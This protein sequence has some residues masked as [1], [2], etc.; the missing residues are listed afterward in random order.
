[1]LGRLRSRPQSFWPLSVAPILVFVGQSPLCFQ[2]NKA[3]CPATHHR[4]L[5]TPTTPSLG[6]G[7]APMV[8]TLHFCIVGL[9]TRM[10]GAAWVN[11][12]P[13]VPKCSPLMP[14]GSELPQLA[15]GQIWKVDGLHP[16]V[17]VLKLLIRTGTVATDLGA[18]V[19]LGS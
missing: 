9:L 6:F 14:L 3:A 12:S 17:I 18:A 5:P 13:L 2:G 15:P 8:C 10:R 16:C 7:L 11:S 4:K 19:R 1:V